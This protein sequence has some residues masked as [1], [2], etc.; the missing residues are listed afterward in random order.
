MWI[1]YC[2]Y[3]TTISKLGDGELVTVL[4]FPCLPKMPAIMSKLLYVGMGEISK[5]NKIGTSRASC[6]AEEQL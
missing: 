6:I 4:S 3:M 1:F 5:Q 2:E